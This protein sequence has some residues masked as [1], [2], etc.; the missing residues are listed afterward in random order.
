MVLSTTASDAR[1][2]SQMCLAVSLYSLLVCQTPT[3][4]NEPLGY[5]AVSKLVPQSICMFGGIPSAWLYR[6]PGLVRSI[7]V[8]CCILYDLSLSL[9]PSIAVRSPLA[10]LGSEKQVSMRI[11]CFFLSLSRLW[12]CIPDLI[13]W[14]KLLRNL[15]I[16]RLASW[17]PNTPRYRMHFPQ[18]NQHVAHVA[19]A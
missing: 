12:F 4:L 19:I 17:P 6:S 2:L 11:S 14:A 13:S 15:N 1:V 8:S 3:F 16:L 7:S 10:V 9:S 18:I 5:P